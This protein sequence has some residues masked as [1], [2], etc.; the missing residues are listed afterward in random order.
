M[1]TGLVI[2]LASVSTALAG[3]AIA[4]TVWVVKWAKESRRA[5]G[6][7]YSNALNREALRLSNE[8][9]LTA[10]E[11][12]ARLESVVESLHADLEK[13]DP[14]GTRA[15]DGLRG[16]LRVLPSRETSGEIDSSVPGDGPAHVDFPERDPA[17]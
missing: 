1:V 6:L 11:E 2:A 10:E 13:L 14:G 16:G 4:M 12:Q 5:Q 7:E 9:K 15:R 3:V 17:A 8:A